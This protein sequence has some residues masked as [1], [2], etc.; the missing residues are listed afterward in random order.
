MQ[1]GIPGQLTIAIF[2][3]GLLAAVTLAQVDFSVMR[4]VA[5][6]RYGEDTAAQVD[7]WRQ[8]VATMRSLPDSEKLERANLFFN[9]RV[10]WAED[11]DAFKKED[12]W[13]TPLE[14]LGNGKGDCEDFAIAKYMTLVLAGVD[15]S[16]LRI[17]YVKAV[18]R[19]KQGL[20]ERAHMVLA[21]YPEP[22]EEP[23]VLDNFIPEIYAASRRTDLTPVY[24]F[25]SYGIW[26]G[27]ASEPAST[28]PEANLSRWRDL[29]RRASEEGLG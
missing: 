22:G 21:Y 12:Y 19:S 7:S 25:N 29:L 11:S 28:E 2:A 13:A 26:V 1:I 27:S 18:I 15:I 4:A 20:Q 5:L 23:V 14:I 10:Q 24:G 9:S 6:E 16:K 8:E 17:T 3:L